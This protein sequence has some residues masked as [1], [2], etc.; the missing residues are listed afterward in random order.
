MTK[1]TFSQWLK[2][3]TRYTTARETPKDSPNIKYYT[4]AAKVAD[5][6]AT[7]LEK[8]MYLTAHKQ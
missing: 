2:W 7:K 5:N 3:C 6:H 1:Q 8:T 4:R